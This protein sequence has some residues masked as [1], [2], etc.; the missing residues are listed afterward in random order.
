MSSEIEN[1]HR[2]MTVLEKNIQDQLVQVRRELQSHSS[3][4]QDVA[5]LKASA[6]HI[7]KA[8]ERIE[9]DVA[10]HAK[11]FREEVALLRQ[12][13]ESGS[14]QSVD[15]YDALSKSISQAAD[16]IEQKFGGKIED[17]RKELNVL[18]S[19]YDKRIAAMK[20]VAAAISVAFVVL[21]GVIGFAISSYVNSWKTRIEE[22]EQS[23][24]DLRKAQNS[25]EIL[26][27]E[28]QQESLRH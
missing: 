14:T 7:A 8:I 13:A 16:R 25:N 27:K 17:I 28:L 24:K 3:T 18:V 21:Q 4:P 5:T 20:A 10:E 11:L 22:S 9:V 6:E 12:R 19:D 2:A 15:R 1:V 23:V 26:I